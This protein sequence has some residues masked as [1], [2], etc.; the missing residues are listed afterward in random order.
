M[1][2]AVVPAVLRSPILFVFHVAGGGMGG[3]GGRRWAQRVSID[4]RYVLSIAA[5]RTGKNGDTNL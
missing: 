1:I 3:G 5:V 2:D 4:L